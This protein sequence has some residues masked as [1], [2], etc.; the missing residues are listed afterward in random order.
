MNS[1]GHLAVDVN[2]NAAMTIIS[3]R[4]FLHGESII[5]FSSTIGFDSSGVKRWSARLGGPG[6]STVSAS[7]LAFDGSGN[8]YAGGTSTGP[9]WSTITTVK[10]AQTFLS[11]EGNEHR[12]PTAFELIQNYPNP[13]NPRTVV[14]Y[15]LPVAGVAKLVVYDLLGREVVVL[16]NERKGARDVFG[17]TGR[18]T[19]GKRHLF[20]PA[21]R[22]GIMRCEEDGFDQV[23][24]P[25]VLSNLCRIILIELK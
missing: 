18:D 25:R 9:Y 13:F 16:V 11:V 22:R 1:P 12:Q 23:G 2:G 19:S 7:A 21:Y 4:A 8:L 15:Q 10:Y 6:N 3:W 14:S 17:H 20:L 24:L 5:D